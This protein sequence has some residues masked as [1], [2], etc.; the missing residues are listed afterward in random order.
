[1]QAPVPVV[2][3]PVPVVQAP[4]PVVQA[5]APVVQA[6]A[7]VVP[8]LQ[9]PEAPAVR[10]LLAP[11]DLAAVPVVQ[12]VPA[13]QSRRMI[14]R[15]HRPFDQGHDLMGRGSAIT[16]TTIG[17]FGPREANELLDA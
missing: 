3:A 12:E 16:A 5:P 1:V 17:R 14:G 8:V 15:I 9:D 2:R 6:P 10:E 11:V 13:E 7:P 4:A